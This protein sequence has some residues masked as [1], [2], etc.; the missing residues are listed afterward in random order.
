MFHTT[1][2]MRKNEGKGN[3]NFNNGK[4]NNYKKHPPTLN[5]QVQN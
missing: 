1:I 3:N 2:N 4:Q 5:K